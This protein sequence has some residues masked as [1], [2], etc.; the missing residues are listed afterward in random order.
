MTARVKIAR[1]VK[2]LRCEKEFSQS[3]V[4]E[5]LFVTQAAY[6][7]MENARNGIN[8]EHLLRMTNLYN[9]TADYLLSG[10]KKL[11]KINYENGFIPLINVRTHADFLNNLHKNYIMDDFEYYRIPGF[12]PT[13]DSILIENEGNSMEPTV[14][15]G[16]ILICQT[17]HTLDRVLD[18]SIV[19]LVTKE[20]IFTKR[21]YKHEDNN[22]FWMESDNP[23]ENRKEEIKK[24]SIHQLLMVMGKVSNVLIPHNEMAFKGKMQFF[25]ESLG[26]L[27]KEVYQLNKKLSS[28]KFKN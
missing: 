6:S 8:L 2:D 21:I 20:A 18:G 4:A 15:S 10:N 23:D 11:I 3:Y 19:I 5:K 12:N 27:N 16:D 13:K 9:V 7:L 28:F 26:A 25:E 17:Q 1:R 24:S 14:L 22:Y